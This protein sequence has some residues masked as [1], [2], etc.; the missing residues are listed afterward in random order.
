[1][2][3]LRCGLNAFG[4]RVFFQDALAQSLAAAMEVRADGAYR[5][6]QG[7]GDLFVALFFLMIED[8]DGSFDGAEL[9][10][11]VFNGLAE[12]AFRELLFCVGR[13]VGE[14]ILPIEGIVF[15]GS[16]DGD[17]RTFVAAAAFPFILSDVDDDAVEVGAKERF[18]TEGGEGAVEA[19]EDILGEVFQVFTTAGKAHES[20]EDHGLMVADDLLE[21]GVG[22][23]RSLD[24]HC[25]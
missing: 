21:I 19:E 22:V 3:A 16:G 13:R 10:E 18:A 20:A 25:R 6:F 12:L 11:P 24:C 5:H 7:S 2:H 4:F 15:A 14:T 17:E 8:E 9:L 23:Q 1:M